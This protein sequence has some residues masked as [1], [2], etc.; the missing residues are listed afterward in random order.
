MRTKIIKTP[1]SH[2]ASSP[3]DCDQLNHDSQF[4]LSS[5]LA[6]YPEKTTRF[7]RNPQKHC[8]HTNTMFF[9]NLARQNDIGANCY[10]LETSDSNIVLDSGMHPK[11][12]GIDAL[13]AHHELPPHS[14]DAIVLS[15]AHLDHAGTIPVLMRD[16]QDAPL[17][18]TQ[19]TADLAKALL[20][21]SVNV[22]QH[23]R[24]ELGITE[25]PLYGHRELDRL[26]TRWEPKSYL[27]HGKS[28]V[29]P[30]SPSTM[31][32]TSSAPPASW[33]NPTISGSS[34]LE[35]SSLKTKPS[36]LALASPK[37]HVDTLI[38]ETTRGA[39]P[40]R[41]DYDRDEEEQRLLKAILDTLER[42]G[43]ALNSKS[44]SPQT[45]LSLTQILPHTFH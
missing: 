40:R 38:V 44:Q 31:P 1:I 33:S 36:S 45:L 27:T 34:T 2:S 23:K 3:S 17:Y 32:D 13:P 25:Y 14:V 26:A 5:I 30:S 21:N 19:P 7:S 29:T 18:L 11:E 9:Q 24:L 39:S 37:K 20:H 41:P 43:S 15:H 10:L 16:Q 12:E 42:G 35:T 28:T 6:P 4:Y 8:A 22:M